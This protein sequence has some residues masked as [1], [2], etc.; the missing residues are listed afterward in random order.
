MTVLGIE[1]ATSVCAAA[2]VADGAVIAEELRDERYIH[3]EKL[4]PMIDAVLRAGT[5]EV[6]GLGG[7]AVSIGPGSFTGLRI[8]L[9]VAK[10]LAYA[11]GTPLVAVPTLQALAE[12]TLREWK[13]EEHVLAA[14]DARRDEVYCQLFR[15]VGG[16]LLPVWEE[17][18]QSVHDC[19]E[20]IGE[21]IVSVTG[22]GGGKLAAYLQASGSRGTATF[23]FVDEPVSRC[24]A[25]VVAMLGE[26]LL[27]GGRTEN[28]A[29]LEPRYVKD[30]FFQA[31]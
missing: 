16:T 29:T 4:L 22:D 15:Q 18:S 20:D 1:T 17:R 12:R 21:R 19:V 13:A 8:G 11:H 9:S 25:A 28:P 26:R 5:S 7:I 2:L 24:S 30:F 27:R 3:A 14:V 6:E 31:R 10:G 23:R